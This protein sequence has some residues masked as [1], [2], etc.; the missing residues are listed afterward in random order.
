MFTDG[1][2]VQT[3]LVTHELGHNNGAFHVTPDVYIMEEYVLPEISGF[4]SRTISSFN[5]HF[6]A[7]SCKNESPPITSGSSCTSNKLKKTFDF[8]LSRRIISLFDFTFKL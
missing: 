1:A 2:A 6:R 8:F 7:V 5:G 4:N 3:V